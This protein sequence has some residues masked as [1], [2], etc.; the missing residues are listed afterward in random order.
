MNLRDGAPLSTTAL[1]IIAVL[2]MILHVAGS[3]RLGR[4]QAHASVAVQAGETQC[5]A[6]PTPPPTSSLP[7]D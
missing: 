5:P 4:S 6:D 2:V 3:E 7:F 1:A